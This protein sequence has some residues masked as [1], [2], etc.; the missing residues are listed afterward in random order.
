ME[1]CAG[2]VG[3]A[4]GLHRAGFQ[5]LALI[6]IDDKAC[7]T[8]ELN[9][10]KRRGWGNCRVLRR[11]LTKLKPVE[12]SDMFDLAPGDLDLLAVVFRARPFPQLASNWDGMMSVTSSPSC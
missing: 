1:I 3:Q 6:E 5:H 2:A 11:D 9:A 7:D 10:T 8:L 4:V 12:L